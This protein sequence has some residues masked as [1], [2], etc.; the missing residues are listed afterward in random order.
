MIIQIS[1]TRILI[2]IYMCSLLFNGIV[3]QAIMIGA[4]VLLA[5]SNTR[6]SSMQTD[7]RANMMCVFVISG[8]IALFVIHLFL[9]DAE[10]PIKLYGITKTVITPAILYLIANEEFKNRYIIKYSLFFIVVL[11]VIYLINIYAF[12]KG[13]DFS[14]A[15]I[16]SV[17]A[18]GAINLVLLPNALFTKKNRS[19]GTENNTMQSIFFLI[20]LLLTV[21]F[22]SGTYIVLFAFLILYIITGSKCIKIQGLRKAS[23]ALLIILTLFLL[24]VFTVG[25]KLIPGFGHGQ[26]DRIAIWT[27]AIKKIQNG[28]RVQKIIGFG[29]NDVKMEFVTQMAHNF[30]LEI[31]LTYGLIGILITIIFIVFIVR[32]LWNYAYL[33]N[34]DDKTTEAIL[35]LF[36]G[37]VCAM[38]H[39]IFTTSQVF[40]TIFTFSLMSSI[41]QDA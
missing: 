2:L 23:L 37:L 27:Y 18:L 36:T 4:L 8:Y 5:I 15:N 41:Y 20:A 17:N 38:I 29:N 40:M 19:Y 13:L 16:G 11:D 9:K 14:I 28:T 30:V 35:I 39:P 7:K 1:K 31:I 10:F 24:G 33:T 12:G 6:T 25:T 34:F 3:A 21:G 22:R 26:F 32:R